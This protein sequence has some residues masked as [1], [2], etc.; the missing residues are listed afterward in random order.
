[1]EAA[2]RYRDRFGEPFG[3]WAFMGY[4]RELERALNEA[5]E[6]GV[7]VT[8]EQLYERLGLDPPPAGALL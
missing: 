7:P 8:E 1:M 4:P 3:T 5:I 6:S 2:D